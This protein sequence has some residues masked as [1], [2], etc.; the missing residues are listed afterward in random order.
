VSEATRQVGSAVFWSVFARSGRFILSLVS[1]V[2][3]VRGL[4]DYDYGVLSLVRTFLTF[5][6]LIAG[7][8]LGQA[9]L[10]FLPTLRVARDV[11][12]A[13]RLVRIVV[14]VQIVVWILLLAGIYL[15]RPVW[16]SVFR[17]EQYDGIGNLVFAA[18]LMS[19]FELFFSMIAQ[20]LNAHYDTK[21]LG[22]AALINH[23]VMIALLV[24]MFRVGAGVLGVLIAGAAGNLA[25]CLLL[26]GHTARHFT[27][28]E[29]AAKPGGVTGRRLA[30]FALPLGAIGVLNMIVWRQSEVFI[31][32]HYRS[33]VETGYFDLA[34]RLPQTMLEFIPLTVWPIIMAG[35]SEVYEKNRDQL[36]TAIDMYYKVL[37]LLIAPVC[38]FGVT[39]GGKMI[40]VLY[41]QAMAPAAV[42]AQLFFV[43]FTLS[44]FSTPLSMS[45][46][47]MEKSHV[48]LLIVLLLAGTNIG[49]DF[50]LIPRY[51][52]PGAIIPVALVIA[53]SPLLYK[54]AL[55]R[56]LA[57]ARI[58]FRFIGKCFAAS[59]PVLLLLPL[60]TR[61]QN[62]FQLS[63]TAAAG[64]LLLVLSFKRF[65][66]L[67]ADEVR[68][69]EGIPGAVRLLRF[70]APTER[71]G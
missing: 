31:L 61:V 44:V 59:L 13:R 26:V 39:F 33:A 67:G 71:S 48:N 20:I 6:A 69:L 46:Y 21:R 37:F 60:V 62:I 43:I 27:A 30:R 50:I 65:K 56:Y 28:R 15:A 12:G 5:S 17:F 45:L 66:V 42:P 51:G 54:A 11:M 24:V 41:S 29:E 58:P 64:V 34:Y 70:I 63:A 32:A 3:V 18:V 7:A 25:A 2:I 35:F 19:I 4:G 49:L 52:V 8:G 57:D 38:V 14:T 1:S 55:A 10:K 23:V 53:V 16:E 47:V 40:P 36:V 22:L 68:L 9:L